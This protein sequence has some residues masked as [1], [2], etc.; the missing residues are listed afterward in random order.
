MNFQNDCA[1]LVKMVSRPRERPSFE[2]ILEEVEKCKKKFQAFSLTHIPRTKNKKAD[3]LARSAGAQTYNV[4]RANADLDLSSLATAA[5][6]EDERIWFSAVPKALPDKTSSPAPCRLPSMR[7]T[8]LDSGSPPFRNLSPTNHRCSVT[9]SS[10]D[11]R[12]LTGI[13]SDT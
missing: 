5:N 3:K 11:S 10:A 13:N 6:D 2:I 9:T 1:D 4:E 8:K 7:Q 12:F